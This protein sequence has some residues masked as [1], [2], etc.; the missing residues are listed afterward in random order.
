MTESGENDAPRPG[1]YIDVRWSGETRRAKVV[2]VFKN[3]KVRVQVYRGRWAGGRPGSSMSD[4]NVTVEP[5]QVVK[6][7]RPIPPAKGDA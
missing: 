5:W 3:G 6:R 4:V 2:K 1:D 7:T